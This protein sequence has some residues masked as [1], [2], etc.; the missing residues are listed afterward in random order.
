[1]KYVQKALCAAVAALLLTGSAAPA[2][3]AE[4]AEGKIQTG[5]VVC[6]GEADENCGFDGKW[7]VLDS[8][9]TNDGQPGMYLVSLNLIGDEQGEDILFRDIGD[10]SVSFSNRGEDFAAEHPGSTDYQGSNIQAWC[11]TFAQ[12]HLSQAEYGA[13]L[14]THKSDE[15]AT[16]PGLGIP[17]PGAPN[18]TVDFSPVTDILDGDKLFLLSAEEVTNP[19]YGFADGSARI[20]Q[21]KGTPQGYWLRS[22]HIPTFPLDVGFVFSFGAVM[23]FPVNANFMFEQ[24]TYAG[25]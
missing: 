5:D 7:L 9:H 23:D 25:L 24:G 18:G 4:T 2:S 8:Q 3:A 12:T 1:M 19:A 11:E 14:P 21:F 22:P 16:I 15:A 10:V 17:L 6:F 13:L 20:A